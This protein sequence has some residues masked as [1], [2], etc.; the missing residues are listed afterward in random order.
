MIDGV[1]ADE[2]GR[3]GQSLVVPL[4]RAVGDV[5]GHLIARGVLAPERC[6]LGFPHPSPPNGHR[7][8]AERQ[9]ELAARLRAWSAA[10]TGTVVRDAARPTTG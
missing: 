1:L 3:L 4:G 6:L 7:Q 9:P 5:I 10:G 8:Y 2:L